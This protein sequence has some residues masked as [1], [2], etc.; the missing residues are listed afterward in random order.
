MGYYC[1]MTQAA[2]ILIELLPPGP[3]TAELVLLFITAVLIRIL[4]PVV[5][6]SLD[7]GLPYPKI[8]GYVRFIFRVVLPGLIMLWL[9]LIVLRYI[10]TS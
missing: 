6:S 7:D 4:F 1:G 9:G 3:L 8:A 2:Q 10:W 5:S